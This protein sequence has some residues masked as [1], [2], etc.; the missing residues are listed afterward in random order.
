MFYTNNLFKLQQNRLCCSVTKSIF[1]YRWIKIWIILI[2]PSGPRH[3]IYKI[4][5]ARPSKYKH[6]GTINI[7]LMEKISVILRDRFL[8]EENLL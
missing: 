7:L 5:R 8:A 4:K 2:V 6:F 3:I 1:Y